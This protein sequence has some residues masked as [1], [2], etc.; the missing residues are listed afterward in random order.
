MQFKMNINTKMLIYILATSI[1]IFGASISYITLNSKEMTKYDAIKI[2]DS[3]ANQYAYLTKSNL[4]VDMDI[5]RAMAQAM[6]S[7]KKI[8]YDLQTDFFDAIL[9]KIMEK[10]PDF[11]S[12][13]TSW[14]LS[15]RDTNWTKDHGRARFTLFRDENNEIQYYSDTLDLE[16]DNEAGAYYKMKVSKEETVMDPYFF[17]YTK[18]KED[19]ILETSVCSPILNDDGSFAGLAGVDLSLDRFKEM[20]GNIKPFEGSYAVL[21]ANNGAIIVHPDEK[22]R[23]KLFSEIF[24]QDEKA[25]NVTNSIQ[26]GI[27]FSFTNNDSDNIEYYVS[28]APIIIGKTITPW[29]L[30][31]YSPSKIIIAKAIRNFRIAALVGL[32]GLIILSTIIT[33]IAKSISQPLISTT[34][35]LQQLA[36]GNIA[37]DLEISIKSKDEIGQMAESV[38][39]LIN[40]LNS[41]AKFAREIGEG[42][43]N[44]E[45]A[46]LSDHDVLGNSLIEMQQSLKHAEEEE[47]KRK[48]EDEKQNWA[49]KGI[50]KFGEIQR[51]NN[52]NIKELS[53][54]IMSNL[55]NYIN[56][57]QGAM[58]VLDINED[59]ES[60]FELTTAIAYGRK[61]LMSK[62]YKLGENLVGRCAYENKTISL[63]E[64]PDDYINIT[65]GLGKSNPRNILLIPLLLND[66]VFGVIELASFNKFEDYQISF[67]EKLSESIASTISG[68]KVNE[69]TNKLLEQAQKQGEELSA[70]EEEMRQNLEELQAT[71]EESARRE[72]ELTG[73]LGAINDATLVME[74][75]IE[76]SIISINDGFLAVYGIPKEKMT[77]QKYSDFLVTEHYD[78]NKFNNLWNDLKFGKTIKQV[79]E[80]NSSTQTHWISSTYTPIVD[81]EGNAY[82]VINIAINITENKLQEE[83]V[84]KLLAESKEKSKSLEDQEEIMTKN[85]EEIA[86]EFEKTE[87]ELR[88]QLEQAELEIEKLKNG[89]NNT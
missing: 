88:Q 17:S 56:A 64:V 50:A 32:I 19:E 41:T 76:G 61:K 23:G 73:T 62:K 36:K 74:Y 15:S 27:N 89:L 60:Y 55:I 13:W 22:L 25:F 37:N 47:E 18:K 70:Q 80:I 48:I 34:K 2:A 52:D 28:F 59:N 20:I 3:Y 44:A 85:M 10:N 24:P 68:V 82:K 69:Q 16:S 7:Y 86:G 58:Y 57:N 33:F 21:I 67:V 39:T 83:E 87:Y 30:A 42:N 71:Q 11:L 12:V 14:E 40:G 45:F 66:K 81:N 31:I 63:L 84:R 9:Y 26:E 8:P 79:E 78:L 51:Q 5:T 29:S 72:M 75:D 4:N 49:T 1:L 54:N 77:G 35:V 6:M 38:N 43:L 53:F 46:L 65:S